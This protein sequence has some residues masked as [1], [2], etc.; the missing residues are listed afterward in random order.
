MK[1]RNEYE[2]KSRLG[3]MGTTPTKLLEMLLDLPELGTAAKFA[4]L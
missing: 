2:T 4:A 3:A 1:Q